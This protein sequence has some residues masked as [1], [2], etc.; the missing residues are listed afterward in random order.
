[1]RAATHRRAA[2]GRSSHLATAG[3]LSHALIVRRLQRVGVACANEP[4]WRPR[5]HDRLHHEPAV[6]PC[7]SVRLF[8]AH[9]RRLGSRMFTSTGWTLP[10]TPRTQPDAP[11]S[12]FQSNV[13]LLRVVRA[14]SR[15]KLPPYICLFG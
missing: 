3:Q 13:D 10:R 11:R 15:R 12:P 7:K 4:A 14:A 8:D 9:P 1:M 5:E 6:T 2:R